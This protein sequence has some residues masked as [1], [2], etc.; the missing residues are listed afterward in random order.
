MI[1]N[2]VKKTIEKSRLLKKGDKV[3]IAYSGGADSTALITLLLDLRQEYELELALAHL[4]HLLRRRAMEDEQFVV[5]V[6]RKHNLPLYLRRENVRAY[7]K[8]H[9]LNIEEAGRKRRYDFLKKTAARIDAAKIATGHTMTDQAETVLM[10]LLRGSGLRGL[11]GISPVVDGLIIRPLI[12]L[13]HQEI[14]AF[15][16]AKRLAYRKDESNLDRRYLRNRVRL[17]LIPYLKKNFEPSVVR[18]LSRLAEIIRG[19][20]EFL[21]SAAQAEMHKVL[22]RKKE[23]LYLDAN[24]LP[25]FPPALARRC[26]RDFLTQVKGDLR[27]ISFRNVESVLRLKEQKELHL[28]GKLI[29]GRE[30]GYIFLKE[31]TQN[32]ISYE[33]SWDGKKAP[34]I[35]ELGLRFA[36]RKISKAGIHSLLFDDD[37]RAY[38]DWSKLR[39]PLTIRSRRQGDL[40]RPLGAPG[41]KKLK[42][43]MRA[44]GIPLGQRQRHPVFLSGRTIVWVLG[45]P[46]AEEFKIDA[47][48]REIFIIERIG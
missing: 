32:P 41:R 1:L 36:G 4:N 20:D 19:E 25:S 48:T 42:E 7:A 10:R 27:R 21:E 9:G 12:E 3:L 11:G 15:L 31:K 35:K 37:R 5:G 34:N 33:Y 39:F 18:Q 6:A 30:R 40:Y 8:K 46:V 26:V 29:L 38:L 2:Q 47:D 22:I 13:E 16:R 44:K 23:K 14:E 45:L 17:E 24:A 43:I 28:P